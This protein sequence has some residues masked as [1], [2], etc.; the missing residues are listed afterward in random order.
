[1]QARGGV[2]EGRVPNALACELEQF[3][4]Q[5]VTRAHLYS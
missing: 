5:P 3:L 2:E 4:Q 1:V